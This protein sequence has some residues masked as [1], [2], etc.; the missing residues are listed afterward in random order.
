MSDLFGRLNS[1]A[2]GNNVG[3]AGNM[4]IAEHR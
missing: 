4:E 2:A 3:R 1:G